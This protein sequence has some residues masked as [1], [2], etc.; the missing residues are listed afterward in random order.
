MWSNFVD[1]YCAAVA[2]FDYG[3]TV[4]MV[5]IRVGGGRIRC[6]MGSTPMGGSVSSGR[7]LPRALLRTC[8]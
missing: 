4:I 1:A 7:A 5:R 3:S 2:N 6:M 8:L